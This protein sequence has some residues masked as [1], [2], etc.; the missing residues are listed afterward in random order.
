M[1]DQVHLGRMHGLLA[2]HSTVT[3]ALAATAVAAAAV[4]AAYTPPPSPRRRRRVQSLFEPMR[5]RH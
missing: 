4:A 3:C 5:G 2:V 1:V